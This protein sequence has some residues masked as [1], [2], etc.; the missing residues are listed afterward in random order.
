M[1]ARSSI[2]WTDASWSPVRGCSIESPGCTN[3]YAM[4]QAHRWPQ[5]GRLTKPSAKGM[6]WTGEVRALE[7]LVMIPFSWREPRLVFVNSQSDTFHQKVPTA[8]LDFMFA[9]MWLRPQHVFQV[10]TKRHARMHEYF[11]DVETVHRVREIA[12]RIATNVR[13]RVPEISDDSRGFVLPNVWLGVSAENQKYADE[14]IPALLATPATIRFVSCEPLLGPI[15]LHPAA[16]LGYRLLSR[17]YGANGFD[18]TGSQPERDRMTGFFPRIDWV[19]TGGESGPRARECEIA[20]VRS[21]I[22]QC[23]R[24]GVAVFN[25]QLGA[26]PIDSHPE[27]TELKRAVKLRDHKGGDMTEWP[28]DLQVRQFPTVENHAEV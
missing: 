5:F 21:I 16:D 22:E 14:R 7:S 4:K 1:G 27:R 17:W 10:L 6:V 12:E 26:R 19:I 2:E 20:W 28:E 11:S 15:S 13:I 9:V 3:C 8:F 25:K 24:A 23:Q 18:E